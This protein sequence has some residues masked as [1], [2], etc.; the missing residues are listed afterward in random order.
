MSKTRETAVDIQVSG[1]GNPPYIITV[2][3]ITWRLDRAA[4]RR[5][6][7]VNQTKDLAI[8]NWPAV[9]TQEVAL[10]MALH[11]I[12]AFIYTGVR[13]S[14]AEVSSGQTH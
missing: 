8:D 10:G 14:E 12:F 5:W 6:H 3:E 9:W 2:G 11:K 13:I 4:N 7:L 1:S